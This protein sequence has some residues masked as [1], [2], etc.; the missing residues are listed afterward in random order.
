MERTMEFSL[1]CRYVCST[2]S[3]TI[4]ELERR[5]GH[6][7]YVG[8]SASTRLVM[9]R[10]CPPCPQMS[11]NPVGRRWKQKPAEPYSYAGSKTSLYDLR[12]VLGEEEEDRIPDLGIMPPG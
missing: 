3:T 9:P 11:T 5:K 4:R 2:L 1:E 12:H 7:I 6:L 8:A 10:M